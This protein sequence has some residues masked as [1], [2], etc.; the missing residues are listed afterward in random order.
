MQTGHTHERP[1]ADTADQ[2]RPEVEIGEL[3]VLE[4]G[5][6]GQYRQQQIDGRV[7]GHGQSDE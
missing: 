7:G 3:L 5:A 1:H 6:V 4:F 2:V